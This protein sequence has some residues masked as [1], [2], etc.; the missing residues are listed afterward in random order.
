MALS[1]TQLKAAL[2]SAYQQAEQ[3]DVEPEQYLELL[4]DKLATAI[5]TYVRSAEVQPG[6]EVQVNTST[7]TGATTQPGSLA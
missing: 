5:D 7:G 3:A 6:M 4:C 2:L 1:R